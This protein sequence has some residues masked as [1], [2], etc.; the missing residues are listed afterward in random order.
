M[1]SGV[2]NFIKR[3]FIGEQNTGRMAFQRYNNPIQ[4]N[5]RGNGGINVIAQVASTSP[6]FVT[7]G[8]TLKLLDAAATGNIAYNT[9]LD[10]LTENVGNTRSI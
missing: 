8:P 7:P 5:Y 3:P 10:P 2:I 6:A 1:L 9:M 4:V